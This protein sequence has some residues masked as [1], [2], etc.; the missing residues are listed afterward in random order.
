MAS[1]ARLGSVLSEKGLDSR[2]SA[3]GSRDVAS[4]ELDTTFAK[5]LG[6]QDAQKV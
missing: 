3:S 2:E 4:V 5:V 6:V 1:K